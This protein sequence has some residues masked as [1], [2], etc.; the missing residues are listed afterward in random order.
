M[1]RRRLT[2]PSK[3]PLTLGRAPIGAW[4]TYRRSAARCDTTPQSARVLTVTTVVLN[5]R[6]LALGLPHLRARWCSMHHWFHVK[7]GS[8]TPSQN[9]TQGRNKHCFGPINIQKCSVNYSSSSDVP[10][11]KAPTIRARSSSPANSMVIRPFFAPRVTLTRVSKASES[12]VER[13]G[14]GVL[15]AR[16]TFG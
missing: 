9:K 7:H 16:S 4:F 6:Q 2:H 8:F 13:A 11:A 14:R 5:H 10:G 1:H 12:R 15:R 3:K